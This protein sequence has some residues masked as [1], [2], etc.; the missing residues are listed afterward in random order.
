MKYA[1]Q[2]R[3]NGQ[4]I[5]LFDTLESAKKMV[6]S[7]KAELEIIDTTN[8]CKVVV[9]YAE[10]GGPN[11]YGH[12]E[13]SFITY[14]SLKRCITNLYK[15]TVETAEVFGPDIR[16][17]RDYFKNCSLTVDGVDKSE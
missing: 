17:I 16:D 3:K 9:R 4:L 14:G 11:D 1:V 12:A 5:D 7:V 6:E 8:A 13:E 15:W 2:H 10:L